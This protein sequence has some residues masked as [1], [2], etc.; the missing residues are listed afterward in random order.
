MTGVSTSTV[1]VAR[2]LTATSPAEKPWGSP[3]TEMAEGLGKTSAVQEED[4][5]VKL[6]SILQVK[7]VGSVKVF[8]L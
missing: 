2:P 3:V 7:I 6:T 4:S 1:T 8:V 5:A